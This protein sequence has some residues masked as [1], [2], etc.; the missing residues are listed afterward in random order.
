MRVD[1]EMREAQSISNFEF[2]ISKQILM[3]KLHKFKTGCDV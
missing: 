1:M 2:R 3:F